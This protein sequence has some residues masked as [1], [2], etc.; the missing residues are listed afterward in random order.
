M[1]T[2]MAGF[3]SHRLYLSLFAAALSLL[4]VCGLS[5]RANVAKK[6]MDTIEIIIFFMLYDFIMFNKTNY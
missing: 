2:H 1:C 3:S 5:A 6:R 4:T